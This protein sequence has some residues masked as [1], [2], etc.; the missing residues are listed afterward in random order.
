MQ[1]WAEFR[2]ELPKE[3]SEHTTGSS[4]GPRLRKSAKLEEALFIAALA[5]ELELPELGFHEKCQFK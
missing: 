5:R 1:K 3:E 2:A 4:N